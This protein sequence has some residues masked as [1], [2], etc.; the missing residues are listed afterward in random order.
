M[1]VTGSSGVGAAVGGALCG[2]VPPGAALALLA[3]VGGG[4]GGGELD[5]VA[6]AAEPVAGLA[7]RED[8]EAAGPLVVEAAADLDL[9]ARV[10]QRRLHRRDGFGGGGGEMGDGHGGLLCISSA[11]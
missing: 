7:G 4:E 8:L 6:Q 11:S 5:A 1:A 9:V 2:S 3:D 10:E